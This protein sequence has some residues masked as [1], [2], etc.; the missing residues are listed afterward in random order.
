MTLVVFGVNGRQGGRF[1]ELSPTLFREGG[2]RFDFFSREEPRMH[3]HDHC[4]RREAKFWMGPRSNWRR[5][6]GE[7][8]G[9]IRQAQNLIKAHT[10]DIQNVWRKHFGS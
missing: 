9:E 4:E 10:D 1:Q 5:I 7:V 6:M 8:I 2:F 3:V